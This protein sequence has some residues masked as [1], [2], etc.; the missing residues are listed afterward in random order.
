MKAA[1]EA[2]RG[3]QDEEEEVSTPEPEDVP[4]DDNK[5]VEDAPEWL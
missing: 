4:V 2:A 5:D 3:A 1:K